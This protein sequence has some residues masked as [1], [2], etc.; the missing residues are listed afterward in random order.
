MDPAASPSLLD[1]VTAELAAAQADVARIRAE[2]QALAEA[3]R[4]DPTEEGRELLKRGAASLSA[5]RDRVDA[6]A[7]RVT[8]VKKTGE[9]FG[10]IAE[11]GRVLGQVAVLIGARSTKSAREKAIDDALGSQLV[12]AAS[13][14]GLVLAASPSRYTRERP[15]R[16]ADGKTVLDVLGRA[17]GDVLVPGAKAHG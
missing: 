9:R 16:T 3:F 6:A 12:D 11:G 14:L 4:A 17:E 5:A 8:L 10:V 13:A 2:N 15:G 7:G 1:E